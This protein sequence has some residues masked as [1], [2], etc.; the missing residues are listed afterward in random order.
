MIQVD[1]EIRDSIV[2][3]WGAFEMR[4]GATAESIDGDFV[5]AQC[6]AA[7]IEVADFDFDWPGVCAGIV[8]VALDRHIVT[9]ADQPAPPDFDR[10]DSEQGEQYV[11]A[12]TQRGEQYDDCALAH[13]V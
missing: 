13:R 5:G 9:A 4:V 12:E 6:A 8:E 10:L 7:A 3:A 2:F 1:G 11:R